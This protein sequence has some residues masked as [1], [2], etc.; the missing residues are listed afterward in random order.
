MKKPTSSIL[1]NLHSYKII[2]MEKAY[3]WTGLSQIFLCPV[4]HIVKMKSFG[5]NL[6]WLI[7]FFFLSMYPNPIREP[8]W[9]WFSTFKKLRPTSWGRRGILKLK[10]LY[11][12]SNIWN[13]FHQIW[14]NFE[15]EV[16]NLYN[17]V[18]QKRNNESD[19]EIIESN[20]S[21]R[22]NLMVPVIYQPRIEAWKNF[23]R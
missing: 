5:F 3:S 2:W 14:S 7:C 1:K 15:H 20:Y 17:T 23:L 4:H 6:A 10:I 21:E 8:F 11:M 12:S 18:L 16:D 22:H 9:G 19:S 13:W